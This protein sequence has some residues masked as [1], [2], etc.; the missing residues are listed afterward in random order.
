MQNF[1]NLLNACFGNV[2]I[3][4]SKQINITI[5]YS[6]NQCHMLKEATQLYTVY[7]FTKFDMTKN[8][9]ATAVKQQRKM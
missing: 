7:I 4:L 2:N 5:Y 1:K 8:L 9:Q 6:L 3:T